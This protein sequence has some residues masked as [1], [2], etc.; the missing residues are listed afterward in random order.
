MILYMIFF[1]KFFMTGK[2]TVTFPGVQGFPGAVEA[3][4]TTPIQHS[5]A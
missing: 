3:L 2:V 5:H 4:H 1:Q